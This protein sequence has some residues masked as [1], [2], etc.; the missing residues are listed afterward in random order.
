MFNGPDYPKALDEEQFDLWLEEGRA[1]KIK[2][3]Y[4]LILWDA[5]EEE[6]VPQYVEGRSDFGD[7]EY[8]GESVNNETIVAIYDLYSEARIAI[9]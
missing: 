2:Y 7:F 8:Y 9:K 1:Q 5:F 4:M 6:Y 3:E